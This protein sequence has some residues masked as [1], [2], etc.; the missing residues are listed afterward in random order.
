MEI[1]FSTH[2]Y[3]I[4]SCQDNV[5]LNERSVDISPSGK[6]KIEGKEVIM[7]KNE[8]NLYLKVKELNNSFANK[9]IYLYAIKIKSNNYGKDSFIKIKI[10]IGNN[11]LISK[12]S[13]SITKFKNHIFIYDIS[14]ENEPFLNIKIFKDTYV[15]EFRIIKPQEFLIFKEYI[16]KHLDKNVMDYFLSSATYEIN[17]SKEF[18][19]Y[20]FVLLF[21]INLVNFEDD[22]SKLE[23]EKNHYLNQS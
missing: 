5:K 23:D 20:E 22:Y 13:I 7:V 21:L 18:I 9:N 4:I 1:D 19:D 15:N 3:F 12:D 14:F 8:N 10:K 17:K 11:N 16:A 6:E 2:L